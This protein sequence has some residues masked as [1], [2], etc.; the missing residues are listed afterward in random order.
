M[1]LNNK[2]HFKL[3]SED[4]QPKKTIFTPN[5]ELLK[6]AEVLDVGKDVVE[7]KTNDV[8]TLHVNAMNML[9]SKEGFCTER[10]PIFVNYNPRIDKVQI[11]ETSKVNLTNFSEASVLKSSYSEVENGEKVYYKEGQSLI[12]PDNTEIISKSQIFYKD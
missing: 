3:L 10:D 8:I 7:I 5:A 6:H 1:V 12:L 11:T 9:D 4:K 2:I